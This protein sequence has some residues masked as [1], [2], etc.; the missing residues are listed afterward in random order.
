MRNLRLYHSLKTILPR[1]LQ[2][3]LRQI[4][5]RRK[6][7]HVADVWPILESA[8]RAPEGW[9]G[10]PDGKQF[11]LVLTHDV[12]TARGV[13]R[14]RMIMDIEERLGFRSVFNF[15]PERYKVPADLRQEMVRRGFEVGVH[16]LYHDL[17]LFSSEKE[18]KRQAKDI[19]RYIKDW[20]AVGFRSPYM[21]RNLKWIR[22]YLDIDYDSSTFDTDP[23]EP[24]PDGVRTI[25][26]F[27]VD[28]EKGG[29]PGYVELPCTLPQDLNLFVLLGE[30]GIDVWKRKLDWI[31]AHGGMALF[32]THP[33]Y[34]QELADTASDEYPVQRYVEFL[35]H[36]RAYYAGSYWMALPRDIASF[37]RSTV[38]Q[39]AM[40]A[41][42]KPAYSGNPGG[43]GSVPTVCRQHDRV[44]PKLIWVDLDNT[45]HV[46]F[47][48]PI[49]HE[50][51][52]KGY[53]LVV[54][55][56]EAFQVCD[57]A[58]RMGVACT[59]V[60][61]HYGKN[62]VM[63]V[64]GL[65]YRA[66]QLAPV[67]LK[68][69]P[70]LAISHGSRAQ[71]IL[72]N[73]LRIPSVLIEDYE[74]AR[75]PPLMRPT[76]RIVPDVI[77]DDAVGCKNARILKYP[78][79]KEDVYVHDFSPDATILNELGLA[80]SD[81]VAVVRPPATEAHYHNP[82]SEELL[83]EVLQKLYDAPSVRIVLLPR[84]QR[85][86]DD[87]RS[88]WPQFF[89][90]NKIVIPSNAVEGLN[91][92]WHADFVVSGGG[93]MNR[94]AAALGVPVYSIF[95]GK[96]G[97][98]DRHLADQG[99]LVMIKNEVDVRSK[100]QVAKRRSNPDVVPRDRHTLQVLV[101]EIEACARA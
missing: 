59:K 8:G 45:P 65:F 53:E 37:W 64:V 63:K 87:I 41:L 56:R 23:F 21:V 11:A 15:V 93:T 71:I 51:R 68:K 29:R 5:A 60:G 24:Q 9:K 16:G 81:I 57:L 12:E 92:L 85:Q 94:E 76:W 83:G 82:E 75:F 100:I 61:R 90:N 32:D 73:L 19:N 77:P 26:P 46:P 84:N 42:K 1:S 69:R 74:Y 30:T 95:R 2:I 97:A 80:P 28:G 99:L 7:R 36:L 13:N 17:S 39:Q 6:R 43:A 89:T 34:I 18:F 79:I 67:I 3:R 88:R 47:F 48:R 96:I 33:D 78:G 55:A 4:S 91:L 27:F 72:A 40:S 14:C 66:L 54:T 38:G 49:I 52:E 31:V 98:V 20:G 10:W 58:E 35:E 22:D 86:A 25:F 50:L 70:V 101:G 62:R 44:N